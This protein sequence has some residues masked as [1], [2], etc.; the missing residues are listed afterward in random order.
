MIN[1]PC[2]APSCVRSSNRS[3][4]CFLT[5]KRGGICIIIEQQ[6]LLSQRRRRRRPRHSLRPRSRLRPTQSTQSSHGAG[7]KITLIIVII[8]RAAAAPIRGRRCRSRRTETVPRAAAFFPVQRFG[9]RP[10]TIVYAKSRPSLMYQWANKLMPQSR[11]AEARA[12]SSSSAA[13]LFAGLAA[14]CVCACACAL[15][16]SVRRRAI[17]MA[18]ARICCAAQCF[19][20]GR[21]SRQNGA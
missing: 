12:Q 4:H 10:T 7:A 20:C 21:H 16:S 17:C 9:R 13:Q 14:G 2:V 3:V 11:C 18:A 5:F 19:R 1:L 8:M 15:R 6:S